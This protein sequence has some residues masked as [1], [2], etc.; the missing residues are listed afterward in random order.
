MLTKFNEQAQKVIVIAESI[1]FDLGH[2]SVGSEHLLL[3]LLKVADV[4]VKD[5][6]NKYGV[7]EKTVLDDIIRLFGKTDQQPF[8]ME[9]SD[10]VKEILENAIQIAKKKKIDKVNVSILSVA[11]IEKEDCVARELLKKYKV[12][13]EEIKFEI[14]ETSELESKLDQIPSFININKKVKEQA[15]MIVGREKE[16][17][18]LCTI[19]SK[20]EKS[21]ALIIGQAGVGKSALVEK[22]AMMINNKQVPK[23]LQNTLIYELSLAGMVAGTKYRGEFEDKLKKVIDKIRG[24]DNVI[25]FID[26]IHNLIGAGGA[27]GAIDASNI[28]KPYLARKDITVIG[29]TTSNEYY[30]YFESEQAMNRRFSLL[31]LK[32][33]TKEETITILE[34]LKKYYEKYHHI[35]IEDMLS[36]LVELVDKNIKDKTFPDKAID[37]LDLSCVKAKFKHKDKVT[38]DIVEEVIGEYTRV[39]NTNLIDYATIKENLNNKIIGQQNVIET[40]VHHLSLPQVDSKRPKGTF[41][42]VGGSGVGKSELAKNLAKNLNYPLIRM[43]MTQY[44]DSTSINKIIGS[45]AGYVGHETPSMLLTKLITNPKSII[46]LDE[47]EK[48][49][50]EVLN[51]FLQIFEEGCIEDNRHRTIYFQDTIFILTS[52]SK[53]SSISMGFKKSIKDESINRYFSNEFLNRIDEVLYFKTLNQTAIEEILTQNNN[54]I[55]PPKKIKELINQYE[56]RYGARKILRIL[57]K[58]K[59]KYIRQKEPS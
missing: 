48:A 51:I 37:I 33:N 10:V 32:E 9:Y 2:N 26:E 7:N 54:D 23:N 57:E 46:L 1:A 56:V 20:K 50:P 52:N 49:H 36:Q 3:S 29:A 13:I 14:N 18:Q 22:L 58:E 5:E 19:L 41:L 16:I 42:F 59:V 55:L 38:I 4:K 27:E 45:P 11:L 40:L 25:I 44:R 12:D 47:V 15:R 24:M 31:V 28:L 39:T 21:N 30:Q 43:D 17:E 53:A 6:L 8:Y 35:H 34:N